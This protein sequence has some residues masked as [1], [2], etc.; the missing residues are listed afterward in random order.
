[1]A[2]KY[3]K[4]EY[5]AV[6]T[7]DES[8]LPNAIKQ[9]YKPADEEGL[10]IEAQEAQGGFL[11]ETRAALEGAA[12]SIS[13]GFSDTLMKEAGVDPEGIEQRKR[14]TGRTVGEI[15]GFFAPSPAKFGKIGKALQHTPL[16]ITERIAKEAA[17]RVAMSPMISRPIAKAIAKPAIAGAIE[18]GLYEGSQELNRQIQERDFTAESIIDST[19]DGLLMGAGIGSV[20][21][22]GAHAA[23]KA[24]GRIAKNLK[25]LKGDGAID[26]TVLPSNLTPK[27]AT[28]EGMGSVPF[29]KFSKDA[30]GVLSHNKREFNYKLDGDIN[31]L[32][33]L[34]LDSEEAVKKFGNDNGFYDILEYFN[35]DLGPVK[36]IARAVNSK[37]SSVREEL[38]SLRTRSVNVKKG[39]NR[40]REEISELSKNKSTIANRKK[41][42][43]KREQVGKLRQSYEEMQREIKNTTTA[44]GISAPKKVREYDGVMFNDELYVINPKK[45]DD[46][47]NGASYSSKYEAIPNRAS[48]AL[49]AMGAKKSDLNRIIRKQ[50]GNKAV[51]EAG[52]FAYDTLKEMPKLSDLSDYAR[53]INSKKELA[54]SNIDDALDEFVAHLDNNGL[55][56]KLYPSE[57][58][59][60]IEG[61]LLPMT[62]SKTNK[63][64]PGH[65]QL[66]KYLIDLSEEYS[67]LSSLGDY[68]AQEPMSPREWRDLRVSLANL[69]KFYPDE[70]GKDFFNQ[71]ITR[72]MED[73]MIKRMESF[74]DENIQNA[75]SLY[76]E[77]KSTY[78]KSKM[79]EEVLDNALRSEMGNNK[80]GLT[81]YIT[82]AGGFGAGAAL[83]G[84][85]GMSLAIGAATTAGRE[86]FRSHGDKMMALYGDQVERAVKKFN[87][88]MNQSVD[89]FVNNSSIRP[90]MPIIAATSEDEMRENYK[91][92]KVVFNRS[93]QEI[94]EDFA[95]KNGDLY[96]I[97]P[98]DGAI[99]QDTAIRA[100]MFLNSKF[101]RPKNASPFYE[102]YQPPTSD[103]RRFERYK[104]F[105]GKP[106]NILKELS[107]GMVTPEA[108]EV[109][110]NVYPKMYKQI[111][112]E[113]IEKMYKQ[114]LT[115]AKRQQLNQ[116]FNLDTVSYMRPSGVKILQAS[117]K[118]LRD[119]Q[120]AGNDRV[121]SGNIE[122][123]ERSETEAQRVTNF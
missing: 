48:Y 61:K 44:F 37:K 16:A 36:S 20:F 114:P 83:T 40:L 11:G 97:M 10:D 25:K 45:F 22:G 120:K 119:D 99:L 62:R 31:D 107:V 91:K 12:D 27:V 86:A 95:A 115:Q 76:K 121:R 94:I 19:K 71:K 92:D 28:K 69:T 4:D 80:L 55:D 60:F 100:E 3:I 77:G 96:E 79:V 117:A 42:A 14:L 101:P 74:G 17:E 102:D 111:E 2:N 47:S 15:G 88:K 106:E 82:G 39:W 50:G 87:K 78:R 118:G 46:V 5:G 43:R 7:I 85:F 75:L 67:S 90:V 73:S 51:V 123:A 23:K 52:D 30:D 49:K 63:V 54:I 109:L 56:S 21:G 59:R 81:S 26:K 33:I 110:T 35:K 38:N 24:G 41:L 8:E 108:K 93:E 58:S 13:M 84:D 53:A 116:L 64:L 32:N 113:V 105:V 104:A 70:I 29:V 98:E 65:K 103:L 1:M 9:G 6:F 112:Y 68:L 122:I 66:E 34:N 57:V 72:F 89:S 18:G